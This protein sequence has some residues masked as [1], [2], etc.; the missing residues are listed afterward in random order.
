MPLNNIRRIAAATEFAV[1]ALVTAPA[2]AAGS[3]M[4]CDSSTGSD[5]SLKL[6]P[7]AELIKTAIGCKLYH[8]SRFILGP[9]VLRMV[10]REGNQR[11][12]SLA[13][14]TGIDNLL[15]PTS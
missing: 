12:N 6:M 2:C 13:F 3:N 10:A 8:I 14:R 4:P 5:V 15:R 9:V 11:T 7:A 1:F